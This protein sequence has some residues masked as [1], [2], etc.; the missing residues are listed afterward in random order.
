MRVEENKIHNL[1]ISAIT[2][3]STYKCSVYKSGIFIGTA[4]IIITNSESNDGNYTLIIDNGN[5]V[6]KYNE[7]GISP[8]NGSVKNPI[9][10]MPLGFTLYDDKG[11]KIN[12]NVVKNIEW[13]VPGTDTLI[14]VSNSHTS[15]TK[16]ADG[17]LSYFNAPELNFNIRENYNAA[18]DKNE[19]QLIITHNDKVVSAKTNLTFVKEGENGTNGT[20]FVCKIVPNGIEGTITPQYPTLTFNEYTHNNIN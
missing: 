4:S 6:F 5:Q 7:N 8:A 11:Q 1:T 3:F 15:P 10:V 13:K 18:Y 14:S 12:H 16:N 19:V 20:D 17:T 2:N 9:V